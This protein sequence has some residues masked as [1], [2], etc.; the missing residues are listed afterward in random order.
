MD[1]SSAFLDYE[2][3][4]NCF[5]SSLLKETSYHDCL[6]LENDAG[7]R[8]MIKSIPNFRLKKSTEMDLK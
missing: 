7:K 8:G 3:Y 2:G 5:Q 1:I 4:N 6:D